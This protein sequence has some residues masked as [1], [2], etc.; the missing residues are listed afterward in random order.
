MAK[1]AQK[2]MFTRT[3]YKKKKDDIIHKKEYTYE[4]R[5]SNGYSV[6]HHDQY[7]NTAN[8]G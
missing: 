7:S 4:K 6:V 5:C 8:S 2:K 3:V 1:P